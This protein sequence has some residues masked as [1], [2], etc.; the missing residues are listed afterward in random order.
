MGQE[1]YF[2]YIGLVFLR[3]FI[4]SPFFVTVR[5]PGYDRKISTPR[6]RVCKRLM[7]P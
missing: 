4:I 2:F 5:R 6:A 7:I 1:L 3:H